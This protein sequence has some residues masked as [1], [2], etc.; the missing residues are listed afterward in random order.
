MLSSWRMKGCI[1]LSGMI[2]C[3]EIRFVH[4]L[5]KEKTPSEVKYKKKKYAKILEASCVDQ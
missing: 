3:L 2:K 1:L 4:T 5:N